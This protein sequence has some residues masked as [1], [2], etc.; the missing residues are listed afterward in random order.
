VPLGA[1]KVIR[2]HLDEQVNPAIARGLR[3]RGIDVTTSHGAGL[4]GAGDREQLAY[5]TEQRR[6]I[7]THDDDFLRLHA[8]RTAHVGVVYSPQGS[9]TVGEIIRHLTLMDACLGQ[10]DMIGQVEY[11]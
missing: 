6:V 9:R 2:F 10:N 3:A 5:A 7:V 8:Q 4:L 11:L 1:E